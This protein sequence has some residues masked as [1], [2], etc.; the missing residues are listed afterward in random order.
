MNKSLLFLAFL[1]ISTNLF[2][3][4]RQCGFNEANDWLNPTKQ[5]R[6]LEMEEK[7]A[8]AIS[9][10]KNLR[11]KGEVFKIPVVV[12]IIHNGEAIGVGSNISAEQV[13]SQIEVLNEDFRGLNADL[14][15]VR[16]EFRPLAGDAE[17]EFVLATHDP[18]GK[19]L[20]NQESLAIMLRKLDCRNRKSTTSLSPLRLLIHTNMP[21]SGRQISAGA[22]YLVMRNSQI[23]LL[24]P[25]CQTIKK[26]LPM[27]W[28]WVTNILGLPIK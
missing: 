1:L 16:T 11:T 8:E 9:K 14:A 4:T 10:R 23:T 2:A 28:S 26:T 18:D 3:Q 7:L 20:R 22:T 5:E 27:A 15:N 17:I 24:C 25:V 19:K 12:H 21:T 6:L 13:Y